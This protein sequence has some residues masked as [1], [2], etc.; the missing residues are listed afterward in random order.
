MTKIVMPA[1]YELENFMSK[2]RKYRS[3]SYNAVVQKQTRIVEGCTPMSV[4]SNPS[5]AVDCLP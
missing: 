2:K 1:N 5:A 4:D 3:T